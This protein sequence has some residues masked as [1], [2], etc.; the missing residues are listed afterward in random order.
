M[1][2]TFA[3]TMRV[4]LAIAAALVLTPLAGSPAGAASLQPVGGFG[5]NPGALDMY[6]YVPDGLP[7]GAPAVVAIHGCGQDA[8]TYHANSGWRRFADEWGFALIYPQ[9]RQANNS[10]GCFNW[11]QSEDQSRDAGEPA[12]IAQMLDHAVKTYSLDPERAYVTGLSAGGA[13]TAIM[14]A[15]YPD[16]FAAGSVVAGLPYQCASGVASAFTCMN[17]GRNLAPSEWGDLVRGAH[18]GFEGPR[19]GVAI[20]HGTAD[21]R[22]VSANATESVKQWTDT[23]GVPADPTDA[24]VIGPGTTRTTYGED[25][26]RLYMVEGM[27]HG[28][29]VD[30]GPNPDQCGSAAPNFLVAVCSAYHDAVFFGLDDGRT[31]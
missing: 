21:D 4:L 17:P 28:T 3:R 5:T 11:F 15:A 6:V 14:L 22:V 9:Q 12:S 19:P 27:G 7:A 10:S 29:P 23:A 8:A 18:P 20:W 31:L 2:S 26:V 25:A 16:R 30:P 24:T 13:M 1:N